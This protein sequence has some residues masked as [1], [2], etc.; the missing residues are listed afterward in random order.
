MI[1]KQGRSNVKKR[2][3][4]MSMHDI[5]IRVSNASC[6]AIPFSANR[7]TKNRRKNRTCELKF[8][9]NNHSWY[10]QLN[11]SKKNNNKMNRITLTSISKKAIERL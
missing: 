11:M 3:H 1:F 2:N 10:F 7:K 8:K 4:Y 5:I 9:K 6:Q